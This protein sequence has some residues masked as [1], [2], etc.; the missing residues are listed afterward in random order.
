MKV[1]ES[2]GS[3]NPTAKTLT[4]TI[5]TT[6]IDPDQFKVTAYY[7]ICTPTRYAIVAILQTEDNDATDFSNYPPD[8]TLTL[9]S[10]PFSSFD[11]SYWTPGDLDITK[12]GTGK[13]ITVYVHHGIGF[14]PTTNTFDDKYIENYK[15]GTYTYYA[16]GSPPGKGA[17]GTLPG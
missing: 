2:T 17:P 13:T 15:A 5:I 14:D 4:F 10:V 12:I 7:N 8:R 9:S 1:Y 6:E 16:A 11:N 3:Y